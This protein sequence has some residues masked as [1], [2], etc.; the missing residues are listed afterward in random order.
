MK[1][2]SVKYVFVAAVIILLPFIINILLLLLFNL[3]NELFVGDSKDWLSFLGVYI[4]AIANLLMVFVA[5]KALKQNNVQL[6]ELRRQWEEE[7]RPRINISIVIYRDAFYIKIKNIG[8][9]NA[10]EI[11]LSFNKDFIEKIPK[12]DYKIM[13]NNVEKKPFVIEAGE[14]KY[15][16][17]G[18]CEDIR[19]KWENENVILKIVGTYCAKYNIEESF[20]MEEFI[21][22]RFMAVKDALWEIADGLSCPNSD[23]YRIQKSL[24]IIAKN[25]KKNTP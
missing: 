8:K 5:Y 15:I 12:E 4:G 23:Y 14:A 13:Y 17:I 21:A 16:L 11:K 7:H 25:C 18:F 6:T 2:K 3:P 19:K 20:L 9:E 10:T 24:D 1:T 22:Q